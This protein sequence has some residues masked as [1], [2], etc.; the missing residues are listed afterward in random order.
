MG[1]NAVPLHPTGNKK[2]ISDCKG[3]N[4]QSNHCIAEGE[5]TSLPLYLLF[6]NPYDTS[7]MSLR[8]FIILIHVEMLSIERVPLYP[9]NQDLTAWRRISNQRKAKFHE[10]KIRVIW[11][12]H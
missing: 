11:N 9:H 10:S 7:W 1:G 8:R 12:A 2:H 4:K 3:F 5:Y 6:I